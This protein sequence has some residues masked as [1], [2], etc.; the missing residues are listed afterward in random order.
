MSITLTRPEW[1]LALPVILGALW[2]GARGSFADLLGARRALAWALR[3]AIVLA[4][5]AALAGAQV[6]R[7]AE[8]LTVVFVLDG[9]YSVPGAERERALEFLRQALAHRGAQHRCAL[10]VFGRQAVVEAEAV[11]RPEEV[12]VAAELDGGHTDIASALR[13][14]L[15]L[16]PPESAGRIVLCSDGNENAGE[17]GEQLLAAAAARIAVDVLPLGTRGES[18]ALV[19]DLTVP[20]EARR[21]EPFS[22]RVDV[23]SSEPADGRLTVLVDD[24][25]VEVR[26]ITL[27]AGARTCELPVSIPDPGFHRVD[28][29]LEGDADA[30]P[31]N[32]LGTGFVRVRGQPRVLVVDASPEE[33][34]ALRRALELQEIEV[35]VGGQ[36]SLPTSAADLETWDAVFLSDFPS[37]RM[38]QQQMEMLRD[39][40]RLRGIGLGMIGGEYGFG[41]GGYYR[42]P[43]EEALPVSM[44]LSKQRA[45]PASAVLIVMDTSGSMGMQEDGYTKIELAAEAGCAVVE[46]L[47]HY[48]SVGFIAS[49]PAPTLIAPLRKLEDKQRV[50]NDI[51]SVRA[52]G[53]GI[54]VFP[55]LKAAYG[56]LQGDA[57]PVRHVILLADGSDCDE[58]EGSVPLVRQMAAERI[59]VTAVAFG[60]GPHVPFLQDVAA[61]G[62]GQFYLTARARDLKGIFTRE[63][64]MVA[65]SVLV[66]ERFR[67]RPADASELCA[68]VDWASA[69][70][71][72][73]YVA[74]TRKE[75]ARTPL[76]SHKDDPLLAH[77]QFGLGRSVAFTSDAKA[78]WAAHW[79]QWPQFT[80]FWGQTVRWVLRRPGS[81]LLHPRIERSGEGR[82]LVVEAFDEEGAP[83]NGLEIRATLSDPAGGSEELTLPQAGPGRYEARVEAAQAGAYVAGIVARGPDGFLAQRTMGFAVPYPP[84]YADVAPDDDFLRRAAAQT[85][86]TTLA[87]PAQV[88]TPPAVFPRTHTDIWRLLLWIAALLLPLDVA[89]RRLIVRAEDVAMA[90]AAV[91]SRVGA[92]RGAPQPEQATV[93][94]LLASRRT[95]RERDR[96]PR[97]PRIIPPPEPTARRAEG[98][99]AGA[100][101]APGPQADAEAPEP[102]AAAAA[103]EAEPATTTGRLLRRK[104]ELRKGG[105]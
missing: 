46:L 40:T 29:L 3:I 37:F 65:K 52:G 10:V 42:T 25:P 11:H 85:G 63:A 12:T 95:V 81:E 91:R 94:H 93:E 20:A 23:H 66:E 28:V 69:P 32:N 13:L 36:A 54:S 71:L 98:G 19:A 80:R 56:V 34:Q 55:S 44:D 103:E 41:A 72:L 73:G 67:A 57:S 61:Q 49:D 60:D 43:V 97:P 26:G 78:H 77:W 24:E 68:G 90:L 89:V 87:D 104:R 82:R 31:D 1:L 59:T 105:R 53:G 21:D 99:A 86:G 30:C 74:T 2:Y 5:V 17:A 79:L 70:P 100:P 7:P 4:L 50:M 88:F 14:A 101:S 96:E 16:I 47:Q 62:G 8:E 39:A 38:S 51:R 76:L 15:G 45:F 58:Q 6:V 27:A 83:L 84:D 9:S 75:L 18:D 33:A 92:L 22:V 48:D 102:D 35:R 64:L